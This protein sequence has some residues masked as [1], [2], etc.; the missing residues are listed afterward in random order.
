MANDYDNGAWVPK[1]SSNSRM[2]AATMPIFFGTLYAGRTLACLT[3]VALREAKV[4]W[5]VYGVC[6]CN[7]HQ[8]H[9]GLIHRC[10][11]HEWQRARLLSAFVCGPKTR[12]RSR[13]RSGSSSFCSTS[14][15]DAWKLL[16]HVNVVSWFQFWLS[17]PPLNRRVDNRVTNTREWGLRTLGRG[18]DFRWCQQR[19]LPK[20]LNTWCTER[21]SWRSIATLE[22]WLVYIRINNI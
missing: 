19:A 8:H 3:H 20:L 9:R 4:W 2:P 1:C 15:L 5:A 11:H 12:S 21:P 16:C 22:K 18:R 10:S 14:S 7:N 6:I 13:A 17:K